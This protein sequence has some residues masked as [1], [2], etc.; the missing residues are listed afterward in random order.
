MEDWFREV[1]RFKEELFVLVHLTGGAPARGTEIISIQ[2]ENGESSRAQRGI[3]IDQGFVQFVTSYHKGYSASQQ[4]KIIHRYVPK[5]IGKLVVYYLWLVEPFVQM[6]QIMVRKQV[7][8]SPFIWEPEPEEEWAD[9]GEEEEEEEEEKEEKEEEKEEQE[10]EGS[11]LGIDSDRTIRRQRVVKQAMNIDGFWGTDRVRRAITKETESRIGVEITTAI[12]RQ[13]YPAIQREYTKEK[14]IVETLDGIY[15]PRRGG[16]EEEAGDE[17][18][19]RQAGHSKRIE[20]MIYGVLLSESPHYTQS[21]KEGFRKV[22]IDWHRF[23]HFESAWSEEN[24]DPIT[25]ARIEREQEKAEIQRWRIIRK[26]DIDEQLRRIAGDGA[27]FRGLQRQGLEAIMERSPR[28]LI[29]MRTGGGKSLFFMIP[30]LCSR[31]GVTIVIV[32]LNSLREDLQQRCTKAGI[33]CVEWNGK[34]PSYWA[35][36]ILVTPESAVT[37]AFARFI[38]EKRTMRQLDR[39]VIDECHVV[40][41]SIRE[42]RPQIKQLIEMTEKGVQVVYLTAT[43]PPK[44]EPQFYEIMGLDEENVRKFRDSTTRKNVAYSVIEYSKEEEEE[45]V[46]RIVEEK[47]AQYPLPG[48]IVVYCRTVK[49]TQG[50]AKVLGC[51]AFHRTVG[52]E[53]EKREILRRL[54]QGEEQVF[55]ATNALGLGIDAPTIRVVIHVGVRE[56]MRGY[57]QESGRAGRDGGRS[58]AILMRGYWIGRDGRRAVEKGWKTEVD[59]KEFIEGKVCRRVVLDREMDGRFDRTDCEVGEEMC[60]ICRGKFGGRKRKRAIGRINEEEEELEEEEAERGENNEGDF[61][62]RSISEGGFPDSGLVIEDDVTVEGDTGG[63]EIVEEERV[64]EE[65]VEEERFKEEIVEEEMFEEERFHGMFRKEVTRYEQQ[66]TIEE[67][68]GRVTRGV[69]LVSIIDGWLGRCV[70]CKARGR[71]VQQ[72]H[73]WRECRVREGDRENMARALERMMEVRFER[74]SGCTFCKMPQKVCH[75]WEEVHGRGGQARFTRKRGGSC[76][77]EGVLLTIAAAVVFFDWSNEKEDWMEKEQEKVGFGQGLE[78]LDEW[79]VG[80]RWYGRKVVS[81]GIEM[82]ELCRIVYMFG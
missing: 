79:E 38:N 32:P 4:V 52:N 78:G 18:R 70:I 58:E 27:R 43:L 59:M 35:S 25:K 15:N 65:M 55:T 47:K 24:T 62:V 16:G 34:R 71:R 30:V 23:L 14:G 50:L 10:E 20:E 45:E 33:R 61:D 11:E 46:R 57:A 51:S 1:K 8:T 76:Q 69:D 53:E 42:W 22:S 28:V 74:Y 6:L 75:L 40:L 63:E 36:I 17:Y 5:E 48:Q 54:T 72:Y 41:D 44:N 2:H 80:K 67:G 60:D 9:E 31:D 73:D 39:I 81:K 19:E 13:V 77:Y 64:E 21:E 12:W 7:E 82:S 3:F 29:V 66:R 68:I 26:T 56:K 37:K 49:Q